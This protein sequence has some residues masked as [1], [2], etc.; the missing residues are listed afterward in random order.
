M[1]IYRCYYARQR[2]YVGVGSRATVEMYERRGGWPEY[3]APDPDM[4]ATLAQPPRLFTVDQLHETH[5]VR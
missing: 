1:A 4:Q 5:V 3:E 2:V